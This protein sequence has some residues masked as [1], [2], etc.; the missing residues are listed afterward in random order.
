MLAGRFFALLSLLDD[1]FRGF[2]GNFLDVHAALGRNHH[3]RARRGAVEQAGAVK[4]LLDLLGAGDEE[5]LHLA[6]L[7]TGLLGDEHLV[8]HRLR[9]LMRLIH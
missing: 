9:E 6:T 7:G 8:K 5:R 4:L 2:L 3:D 1:F